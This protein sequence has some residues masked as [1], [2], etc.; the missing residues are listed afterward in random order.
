METQ[1]AAELPDITLETLGLSAAQLASDVITAHCGPT[2]HMKR[3]A[4]SVHLY[5]AQRD[6]RSAEMRDRR[7]LMALLMLLNH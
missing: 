4:T 3:E 2:G 5:P 7:E 6:Y 1:V